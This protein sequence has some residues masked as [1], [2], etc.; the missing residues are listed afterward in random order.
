MS[1][2]NPAIGA[3]G[4]ILLSC[5]WC[6]EWNRI[7]PRDVDIQCFKCGRYNNVKHVDTDSNTVSF[8]LER[9]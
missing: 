4:G 7:A 2:N 8:W 5:A 9:Q 3:A 1:E 6:G